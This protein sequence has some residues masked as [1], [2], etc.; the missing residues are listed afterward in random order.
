MKKIAVIGLGL[1]GGSM[2]L[3][4]KKRTWATLYGIDNNP[5]HAE[6]ALELG[7]VFEKANLDIVKDVDVVIIAVPV[8][9]IPGLV[10]DVLDR[11]GE[12]T[13]VLDVGSVKTE[14]CAAVKYHNKRKNYVAA[15]PIAGTEFSGP[16]AAMYDL[17]T[18]KINI[19]CEKDLT[20]ANILK[21]ALQLFDL[22]EMRSTFME[23]LEHDKHIA[24]VS[25]LS[26]ISSFM[27]GKTVLE[28]EP[29]EKNIFNMAGSGFRSTVRL[30][31]SSPE[32]WTPIFIQNKDNILKSLTEYIKNLE[33]FKQLIEQ[34]SGDEVF[35][36]MQ[37]TNRIKNILD[38]IVN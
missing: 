2:A 21:K 5:A 31:K 26:H 15:H 10:I 1:I 18:N 23:P 7:I 12:E 3:E 25:H 37:S 36:I 8:N 38:G 4:L 34:G 30:A 9:A 27:L 29:D 6:K 13:L 14:V 28:I 32:M 22:L 16:E 19:I 33:T 20:D 24:Y 11:I 35:D 17:F